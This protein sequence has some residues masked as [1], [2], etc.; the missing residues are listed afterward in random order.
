MTLLSINAGSS[1]LKVAVFDDAQPDE[2]RA[3]L[4]VENIES[5]DDATKQVAQWLHAEQSVEPSDVQ[6]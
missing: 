3:S 1:S 6:A 5:F 2:P 4:S